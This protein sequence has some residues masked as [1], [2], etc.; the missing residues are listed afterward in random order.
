M[1]KH[2]SFIV[3]HLCQNLYV[4]KVQ[5]SLRQGKYLQNDYIDLQREMLDTLNNYPGMNY[6]AND[7][8]IYCSLTNKQT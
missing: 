2:I 1:S 5:D 8:I 3:A 6:S 7:C 4:L